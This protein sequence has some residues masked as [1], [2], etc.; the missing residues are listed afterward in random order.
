[1]RRDRTGSPRERSI[2]RMQF[3]LAA[4]ELEP[5][6]TYEVARGMRLPDVTIEEETFLR[7][8]YPLSEEDC[9]KLAYAL[10]LPEPHSDDELSN[11]TPRESSGEASRKSGSELS[12]S[13]RPSSASTAL[14]EVVSLSPRA[15]RAVNNG[16]IFTRT[17]THPERNATTVATPV[18]LTFS[19]A[20]ATT[21]ADAHLIIENLAGNPD[22]NPD[23]RA[24]VA[25]G[26]QVPVIEYA[27][28]VCHEDT[29][30]TEGIFEGSDDMKLTSSDSLN[31][32]NDTIDHPASF[33]GP[34]QTDAMDISIP[35]GP[36]EQPT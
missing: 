19:E 13:S 30:M 10:H 9:L 35:Q 36:F 32:T 12:G 8:P 22:T 28:I 34:A 27:E 21:Q 5:G 33:H 14:T 4:L 29:D 25:S 18:A 16:D 11:K 15:D 31:D 24:P 6:Q 3:S 1:M 17:N 2:S 20:A 23:S 7:K 26:D